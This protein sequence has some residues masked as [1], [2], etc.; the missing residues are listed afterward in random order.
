MT[1]ENGTHVFSSF[2][3]LGAAL[4]FL[5][6]NMTLGWH[7]WQPNQ[8]Q[9]FGDLL[10]MIVF[11]IGMMTRAIEEAIERLRLSI[12]KSSDTAKAGSTINSQ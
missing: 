10:C 6:C 1:T 12:V 5:S 8:Q 3:F 9:L 11:A 7:G 2:I 4:S